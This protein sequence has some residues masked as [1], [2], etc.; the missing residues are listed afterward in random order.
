MAV[1]QPPEGG[2]FCQCRVS[3]TG[4]VTPLQFYGISAFI[5]YLLLAA[6]PV[7]GYLAPESRV[8]S[9]SY[10]SLGSAHGRRRPQGLPAWDFTLAAGLPV[11]AICVKLGPWTFSWPMFPALILC[12]PGGPP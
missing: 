6:I 8:M 3:A 9:Q 12:L 5:L 2:L 4:D 10:P 1:C 7:S 11:A